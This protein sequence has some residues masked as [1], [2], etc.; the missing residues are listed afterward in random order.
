MA[1]PN[2]LCTLLETSTS[3]HFPIQHRALLPQLPDHTNQDSHLQ[4]RQ[5]SPGP[6]C[7]HHWALCTA[8]YQDICEAL[9]FKSK[10]YVFIFM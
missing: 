1:K 4:P 2:L 10:Y 8:D 5:A 6:A 7:T 9:N 3:F